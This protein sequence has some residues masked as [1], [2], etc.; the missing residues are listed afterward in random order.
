MQHWRILKRMEF[1]R[2]LEAWLDAHPHAAPPREMIE[3]AFPAL[4]SVEVDYLLRKPDR[5]YERFTTP[6]R[7]GE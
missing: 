6:E 7:K 5:I 2:K 3:R 4:D 1:E